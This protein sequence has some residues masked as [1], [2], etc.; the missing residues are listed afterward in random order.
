V[1]IYDITCLAAGTCG[2]I[3]APIATKTVVA[4][5]VPTRLSASTDG[6]RSYLFVGGWD[7]DNAICYVQREFLFDV[8]SPTAPT[9]IT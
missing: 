1:K 6:G 9:E 7:P 5:G 3:G 4:T 8:T 2:A